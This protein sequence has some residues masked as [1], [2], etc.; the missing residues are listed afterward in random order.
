MTGK[1]PKTKAQ[2]G[3]GSDLKVNPGIGSSKGSYMTGEDPRTLD[4]DSTF[5]GDVG[6]ETKR[7]GGVDPNKVGRTNK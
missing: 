4:A 3:P 5:E 2:E 6:N 1:H 7:E